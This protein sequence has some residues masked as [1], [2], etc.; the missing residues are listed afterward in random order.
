LFK[1]HRH[2]AFEKFNRPKRS[3][4]RSKVLGQATRVG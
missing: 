3:P 1:A 4:K 2:D